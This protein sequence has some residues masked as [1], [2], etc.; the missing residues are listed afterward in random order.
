M[1]RN[2]LYLLIGALAVIV[3]VLGVQLQRERDKTT[4]VSIDISK[5]HGLTI[6]HKKGD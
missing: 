2:V 1:N 5:E 4:G 3:V 6:E